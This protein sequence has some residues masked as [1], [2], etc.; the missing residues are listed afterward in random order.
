MR[1][2]SARIL[3]TLPGTAWTVLRL[4]PNSEHRIL[5]QENL[6]PV[7]LKQIMSLTLRRISWLLDGWQANFR[8]DV[9]P[10]YRSLFFESCLMKDC[11]SSGGDSSQRQLIST[12]ARSLRQ[13]RKRKWQKRSDLRACE[14]QALDVE[15]RVRDLVVGTIEML[16]VDDAPCDRREVAAEFR[17]NSFH[18]F[19]DRCRSRT[20]IL[21]ST[22]T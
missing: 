9:V 7:P 18:S 15:F 22:M 13:A 12:E 1:R 11:W 2:G 20:T 21:P 4:R 5:P 10:R 6:R 3:M 16:K 8:R 19:I 17:N 14:R